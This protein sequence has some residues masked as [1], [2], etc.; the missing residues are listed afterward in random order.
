MRRTVNYRVGLFVRVP[1]K[2][3][4]AELS[5]TLADGVFTVFSGKI[6]RH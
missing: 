6:S 3:S 5:F 1:D 4:P 2:D